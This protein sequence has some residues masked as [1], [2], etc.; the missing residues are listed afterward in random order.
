VNLHIVYRSCPA[1]NGKQ[2][3]PFHDKLLS[4]ASFARALAEGPRP[5]SMI[6]LNDGEIP[7]DR[8]ALMRELGETAAVPRTPTGVASERILR[9]QTGGGIGLTRSYFAALELPDKRGWAADDVV[10]FVEDDYL[11]RPD[12]LSRL[13]EAIQELPA[14]SYFALYGSVDP[15]E[16]VPMTAGGRKWYTGHSTTSTFA[17]R[18]GAL[19]QDRLIHRLGFFASGT[20][21]RTV[22]LA[23]RGV[24]PFAWN[25]VVGDLMGGAPEGR[26]RLN[27]RLK[28]ASLQAAVNGLAMRSGFHRHLLLV[29]DPPLATH[30]ESGV[31]APGVDWEAV[32]RDTAAWARSGG[33]MAAAGRHLRE[34]V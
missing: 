26:G 21:D 11:H 28:R 30:V 23:Y 24:R 14:A 1:G 7:D 34:A 2:R 8:L 15:L 19:R 9:H 20:A 17:A 3:P 25:H 29:A 27:G 5:A 31:L 18:V 4:L 16:T 13:R 10:Y 22:C 6:F 33:I 12:A 32:A